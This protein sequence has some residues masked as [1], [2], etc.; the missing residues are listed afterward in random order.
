MQMGVGM[1]L[2]LVEANAGETMHSRLQLDA[3]ELTD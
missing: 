1:L 3:A 2:G